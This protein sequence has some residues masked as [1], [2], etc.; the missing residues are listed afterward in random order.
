MNSRK[1]YRL[2]VLTL[3][4]SALSSGCSRYFYPV[5]CTDE[6]RPWMNRLAPL[7]PELRETSGLVADNGCLWTMNDSGGEAALYSFIPGQDRII[8]TMILNSVNHD[9]EDLAEDV[10]HIYIADVGNNFAK[11]DTLEILVIR[12]DSLGSGIGVPVESRIRFVFEDTILTNR[13]GW[14]S[15]DCEALLA[16][17]DSLYLFTKNWVDRN[18]ALYV[19][20]KTPGF[21]RIRARIILNV[22]AL[23]T[24]A[25]IFP[26]AK[27]VTLVGYRNF[28]PVIMS[29]RFG[30]NPSRIECA[31]PVWNYPL[32]T[33]R[34]VEGIC[35]DTGGSLYVSSEGLLYRPALFRLR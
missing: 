5:S 33:G 17:E 2:L 35:Y 13:A 6:P 10:E 11:R 4:L 26:S 1:K 19:L 29:Y 30:E 7:D 28:H 3:F 15:A 9:W 16:W 14:S 18:T 8:K 23:I 21:Y 12:K 24:G 20:P 22:N 27:K 32:K 34:Q 31:G 25:D